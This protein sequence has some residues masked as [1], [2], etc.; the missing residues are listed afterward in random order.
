MV[1]EGRLETENGFIVNASS[2]FFNEN[3]QVIVFPPTSAV[4]GP[5]IEVF[6]DGRDVPRL[7][8]SVFCFYS[9][10]PGEPPVTATTKFLEEPLT[11]SCTDVNPRL[12]PVEGMPNV[13]VYRPSLSF[14]F[15]PNL[16]MKGLFV[17]VVYF[18]STP[19]FQIHAKIQRSVCSNS[20]QQENLLR[21]GVSHP[22]QVIGIPGYNE[23]YICYSNS[24]CFLL[25]QE[26]DPLKAKDTAQNFVEPP[27]HMQEVFE[28]E[29]GIPTHSAHSVPNSEFYLKSSPIPTM[30]TSSSYLLPRPGPGVS[31]SDK[32]RER[33]KDVSN[34]ASTSD[35]SMLQDLIQSGAVD[36]RHSVFG[37][38]VQQFHSASVVEE[39]SKRDEEELP[40]PPPQHSSLKGALSNFRLSRIGKS[41]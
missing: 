40:A 28:E 12:N 23:D 9:V 3:A 5:D 17:L 10:S 11:N 8:K 33:M 13:F 41:K 14:A 29:L 35:N 16:A 4:I 24:R 30:N 31:M 39:T 15:H 1:Y 2:T 22:I 27:D 20:R 26:K 6:I 37:L 25:S 34:S 36:E 7:S 32:I 38:P 19:H 18:K 21:N